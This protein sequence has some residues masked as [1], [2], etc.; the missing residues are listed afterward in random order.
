MNTHQQIILETVPFWQSI[1]LATNLNYQYH[2]RTTNI[3]WSSFRVTDVCNHRLTKIISAVTNSSSDWAVNL[4]R[5]GF[6]P[7]KS[8]WYMISDTRRS[9]IT[10][11][12]ANVSLYTDTHTHTDGPQWDIHTYIHDQSLPQS[13]QM[14]HSTHKHTHTQTDLTETYTQ[15]WSVITSKCINNTDI[16]TYTYARTHTRTISCHHKVSKG[17]T[18]TQRHI[19]R[20]TSLRH[21]HR[22]DQSSPANVSLTQTYTHTHYTLAAA[23]L[24]LRSAF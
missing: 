12:S 22:H 14:Y 10:S 24:K 19:H 5:V 2:L 13:Q 20:R 21:T 4:I 8:M 11:K 15:T 6:M 9:V 18:L 7:Y 1:F 17:I 3:S 23:S 16:H